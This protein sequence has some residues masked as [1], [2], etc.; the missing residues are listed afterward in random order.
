V[1]RP[2][3]GA[4]P[5]SWAW[6]APDEAIP[7]RALL[8]VHGLDEPGGIWD[9]LAE[10]AARD[11][12]AV[13]R[14][15]Y[16]NDAPIATGGLELVEHLRVLHARGVDRIVVVGHS[17]GGL[18]AADAL[19][20]TDG[21]ASAVRDRDALPEVER[22]IT[23][24]TPWGGSELARFRIVAEWREQLV[25]W[26]DDP[27]WDPRPMLRSLRDGGGEAGEDL[28]PGSAFLRELAT[29]PRPAGL[30]I[31]TIIGMLAQTDADDIATDVRTIAR[32]GPI[33]TLLGPRRAAELERDALAAYQRAGP[34]LGDGV[35]S[36]ASAEPPEAW[37]DGIER[38]VLP[39]SHRGLLETTIIDR[40]H[41]AMV[42]G[43]GTAIEPP[44]IAEIVSRLGPVAPGE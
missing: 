38:I 29:R 15:D 6:P 37:A 34:G 24:G 21:Y 5:A 19:T 42:N 2:A 36:L 12:H 16:P 33:Q 13:L 32:S 7:H 31:T 25:R 10:R 3:D 1:Y 23:I 44:A 41:G 40:A 26:S 18:V 8:L 27:S 4:R 39:A 30:P 28:L 14:F 17:M 11:G 35:V 9:A 43:G 22:L 20:R